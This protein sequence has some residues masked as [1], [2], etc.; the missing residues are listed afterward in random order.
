VAE[1]MASAPALLTVDRN[2]EDWAGNYFEFIVRSRELLQGGFDRDAAFAAASTR[3]WRGAAPTE[4]LLQALRL[5]PD[6][7]FEEWVEHQAAMKQ[8]GRLGEV[9]IRLLELAGMRW[10]IMDDEW[11]ER[12]DDFVTFRLQHGDADVDVAGREVRGHKPPSVVLFHG[13]VPV[14]VVGGLVTQSD[15]TV[16]A[17]SSNPCERYA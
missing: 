13:N 14:P 12:F 9:R 3:R 15:S 16:R 5:R 4:A 1:L 8:Q 2:E 17:S 7:P 10:G 6:K 11:E